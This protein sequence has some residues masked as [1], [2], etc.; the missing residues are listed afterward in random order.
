MSNRRLTK[1]IVGIARMIDL[2]IEPG[3]F[4]LSLQYSSAVIKRKS[5]SGVDDA[6]LRRRISSAGFHPD[7]QLE[8]IFR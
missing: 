6:S 4:L 2:G 3:L 1:S 8:F 7:Q 5:T